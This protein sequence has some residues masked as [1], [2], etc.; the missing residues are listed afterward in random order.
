MPRKPT[1]EQRATLDELESRYER[2]EALALEESPDEPAMAK[3]RTAVTRVLA[4]YYWER[5]R[6]FSPALEPQEAPEELVNAFL[7]SGVRRE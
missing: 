1:A 7:E 2:L 3:D 4:S 5:L 6:L